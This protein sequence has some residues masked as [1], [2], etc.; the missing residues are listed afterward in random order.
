METEPRRG[1]MIISFKHPPPFIVEVLGLPRHS[2]SGLN[3]GTID[4]REAILNA[5]LGILNAEVGLSHHSADTK[6][7]G[8]VLLWKGKS[9]ME[10]E[11]RR[12][13]MIISF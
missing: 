5:E 7:E 11:L 8:L 9:I 6:P 2:S 10:T 3:P 13:D 1:D 12:D 4:E